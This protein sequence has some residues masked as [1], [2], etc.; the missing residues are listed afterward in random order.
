[1]R[2][3]LFLLSASFLLVSCGGG[4]SK[5][6]ACDQRYWDGTMGTCLPEKWEIL[7]TETLRQRGVPEET[8]AAFQSS[9]SF[10]GQFPTVAITRERLASIVDPAQYSSANMRSVEVLDGYEH[11][12]TREF[13]VD[14]S[15]VSLHIFTGQPIEG[16]PRR[17]FY[18]VSTT[19][20][21][22]GYTITAVTPLSI[23]KDLDESIL[24]ILGEV[25]FIEPV[26]EKE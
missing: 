12:D 24:L 22:T 20:G 23:T 9:E 11:V 25:T 4:S 6:V 10:S 17:R 15:K 5:G 1:M 8:I 2:K 14:D 7:N 18:Q 16:E 26:K 13:N 21:D 3:S 19:T